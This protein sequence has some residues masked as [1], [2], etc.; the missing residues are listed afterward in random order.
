VSRSPR[1]HARHRR[2]RNGRP[3]SPWPGNAQLHSPSA[4]GRQARGANS[5][6][7][8]GA[9][10]REGWIRIAGGVVGFGAGN[11]TNVLQNF[12]PVSAEILIYAGVTILGVVTLAYLGSWSFLLPRIRAT[13]IRRR[14]RQRRPRGRT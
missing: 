1:R 2:M 4:G 8:G 3:N 13:A 6:K 12:L 11:L 9:G 14:S 5:G 7:Q 10:H